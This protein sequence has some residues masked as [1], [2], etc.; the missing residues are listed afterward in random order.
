MSKI[1]IDLKVPHKEVQL[2]LSTERGFFLNRVAYPRNRCNGNV[3][4]PECDIINYISVVSTSFPFAIVFV[5]GNSYSL[6]Y[7]QNIEDG[8][9]ASQTKC[10]QLRDVVDI[11]RRIPQGTSIIY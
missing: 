2:F 7:L 5:N 10:R 1:K 3:L 11:F 4:C 9:K 8:H 6:Y